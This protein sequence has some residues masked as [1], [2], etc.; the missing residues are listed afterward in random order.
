M[1]KTD[2]LHFIKIPKHLYIYLLCLVIFP[3]GC[4]DVSL[5]P[6]GESEV[7]IHSKD[8]FCIVDPVEITHVTKIMFI[9][10]VS[11]SNSNN[12]GDGSKR[13]DNINRFVEELSKTGDYQYGLITFHSQS[14]SEI[15]YE[16]ESTA[17]FTSD[18]ED[19]YAATQTIRANPA[20]SGTQYEPAFNAVRSAILRDVQSFPNENTSYQVLFISDGKPSDR[21]YLPIVSNLINIQG[22]MVH[23]STAYYGREGSDA[24]STLRDIAILGGGNFVNFENGEDWDLSQLVV[25]SDVIP[26][27]LKQFL[28]YNLNAGFCLDGTVDVDSDVDGMCDKDEILMN[29]IYSGELQAEGK[30]FDPA[31]RFSFGDGYGDFYHWL[32]FRYPGT[33]LSACND[34]S[35]NDFDLL[36]ACEEMEL[37][38]SSAL[39]DDLSRG[40][41]DIF[42]TDRDGV[43]D[44]IETYV[45]FAS[46]NTGRA[47]RYTAALDNKNLQDSPDGEGSVLVQIRQHRNPLVKDIDTA[48]SY[49]TKL[50]PLLGSSRDCYEFSQTS[51][52]LYD[53]LEVTS[54]NTLPG[55]EHGAGENSIMVYYIQ[56]LQSDPGSVGVLKYSFQRVQRD[57]LNLGLQV[58]DGVFNEYI[59]PNL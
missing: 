5:V 3:V 42:D 48:V 2:V 35:D 53:T 23:I 59:P 25:E 16:G 6:R 1:I 21:N 26:W 17:R 13:A 50:A 34:R 51:L 38:N 44:G 57:S 41:P 32:R 46:Q 14:E 8:S 39:T 22:R 49:D 54:G 36:T 15:Y 52:P 37:K 30:S 9:V 45:Y 10:D 19:V 12:D 28:V 47:T 4:V 43:I 20:R 24:I 33:T 11:G 31:N 7:L 56:V 58:G 29:S 18:L 55:L 40:N 27:S